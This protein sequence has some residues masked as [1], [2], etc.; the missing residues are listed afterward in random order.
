MPATEAETLAK[1]VY[2]YELVVSDGRF[3]VF[4]L[5]ILLLLLVFLHSSPST[6]QQMK[7]VLCP[8]LNHLVDK[9]FVQSTSIVNVNYS[10]QKL[11]L[12]FAL[13]LSVC[14]S[15]LISAL[16]FSLLLLMTRSFPLSFVALLSIRRFDSIHSNPVIK[17]LGS[18]RRN[19]YWLFGNAYRFRPR[20]GAGHRSAHSAR[21][22]SPSFHS[23]TSIA[24]VSLHLC[25]VFSFH[26]PASIASVSL[27]GLQC[28][29]L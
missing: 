4:L 22:V 10:P 29:A 26:S 17:L 28:R 9:G 13:F 24:S 8:S 19:S 20:G 16:C 18:F 3:K 11:S 21:L 7:C 1:T 12:L 27:Q 14:L 23:R 15:F 25:S 5:S 2:F 6:N